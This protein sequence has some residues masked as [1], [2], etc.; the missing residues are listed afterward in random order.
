[1]KRL[2]LR[3]IKIKKQEPSLQLKKLLEDIDDIIT[4]RIDRIDIKLLNI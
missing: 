2:P 3:K 4:N 1:M